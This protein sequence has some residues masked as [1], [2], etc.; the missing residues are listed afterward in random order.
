MKNPK[1]FRSYARRVILSVVSSFALLVVLSQSAS[2]MGWKGI[3]PLKSRR[4][5]VERILGK[6]LVD[7]PG[8]EGTL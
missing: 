6:P 4:A 7:Q 8:E 2:A 3:E 1:S 5:D